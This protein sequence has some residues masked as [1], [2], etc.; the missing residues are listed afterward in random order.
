MENARDRKSCPF[1]GSDW[2]YKVEKTGY[3]DTTPAMFCNSCKAV[4]TWEQV[5]EEGMSEETWDFVVEHWN[6]RADEKESVARLEAQVRALARENAEL[7]QVPRH[8]DDSPR[9]PLRDGM[10]GEMDV[11]DKRCA[12]LV[13][14]RETDQYKVCAVAARPKPSGELTPWTPINYWNEVD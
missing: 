1:C 11:C 14:L 13:K 9:C 10:T 4:V 3:G 7:K 8:S 6:V 12:W 5:E 2:T